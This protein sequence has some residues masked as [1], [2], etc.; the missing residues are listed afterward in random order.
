MGIVVLSS[1]LFFI[2]R[3]KDEAAL[4]K[5]KKQQDKLR[6][7]EIKAQELLNGKGM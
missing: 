4:K 5:M 7:A 2:M 1:I 6:L 3:D